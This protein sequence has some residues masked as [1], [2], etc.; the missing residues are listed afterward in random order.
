[1]KKQ[2][3]LAVRILSEIATRACTGGLYHPGEFV[4]L[5]HDN[6]PHLLMLRYVEKPIMMP[7]ERRMVILLDM[8]A[9]A[10]GN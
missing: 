3:V 9:N 2:L 4:A 8:A 1:M 5:R 7:V 6:F 10:T